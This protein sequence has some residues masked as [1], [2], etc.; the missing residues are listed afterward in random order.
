MAGRVCM[1][2]SDGHRD[3]SW[4]AGAA[5]GMALN[6]LLPRRRGPRISGWTP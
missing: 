1:V 5:A 3:Q 4:E 2:P 6:L